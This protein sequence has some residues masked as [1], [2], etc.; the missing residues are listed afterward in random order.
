LRLSDEMLVEKSKQGDLSAYGELVSRYQ[1]QVYNLA[2]RMLHSEEDAKDAAQETFIQTYRCIKQFHGQAKFSTWL[3]RIASNKCLDALRR[4]KLERQVFT[5]TINE[6]ARGPT[7]DK[8]EEELLKKEQNRAV[9]D[10]LAGLPEKYRLVLV[11]QHYHGLSYQEISLALNLPEKTVATRVY[12]AKQMLKDA[13]VGGEEHAMPAGQE[14]P[15][16]LSGRRI[17][18]L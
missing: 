16:Q 8:P 15:G 18:L 14:K 9:R 12:R 3:Y 7:G 4:G 2:V 17:P 5:G 6:Q 1:N 11:L 10:A 13:L